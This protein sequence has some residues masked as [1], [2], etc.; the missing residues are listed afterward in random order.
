MTSNEVVRPAISVS[1]FSINRREFVKPNVMHLT[2]V[3]VIRIKCHNGGQQKSDLG[4]RRNIILFVYVISWGQ[5]Q[6]KL[7]HGKEIENIEN[8]LQ[9]LWTRWKGQ[10]HCML[11]L[12]L[13]ILKFFVIS[14]RELFII[15]FSCD[16]LR[17]GDDWC[18]LMTDNSSLTS[19]LVVRVSDIF[20]SPELRHGSHLC[21]MFWTFFSKFSL[22]PK[23]LACNC[24]FLCKIIFLWQFT[25]LKWS[26][27]WLRPKLKEI[28]LFKLH[29]VN[30][31]ENSRF[32]F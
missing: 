25:R 10:V 1:A 2:S 16:K 32:C 4:F 18:E 27:D 24:L 12:Q 15:T 9:I 29:H 19:H 5:G 23:M 26:R 22:F 8:I 14:E 7:S 11:T 20:F 6:L 31:L 3:P 30:V 13:N 28:W 17:T 21:E